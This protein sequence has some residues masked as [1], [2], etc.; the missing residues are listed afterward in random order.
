[1]RNLSKA[2]IVGLVAAAI[3]GE[4]FAPPP[5]QRIAISERDEFIT[6]STLVVGRDWTEV[7]KSDFQSSY[8]IPEAIRSKLTAAQ[9]DELFGPDSIAA[10]QYRE[11]L[12]KIAGK[13]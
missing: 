12:E 13:S 1:M 8:L 7:E 3:G 2:A 5:T 4:L 6:K 10:T 11:A 9:I